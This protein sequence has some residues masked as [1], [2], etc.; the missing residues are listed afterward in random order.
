[1]ERRW[2]EDGKRMRMLKMTKLIVSP[3]PILESKSRITISLLPLKSL[4]LFFSSRALICIIKFGGK[5]IFE[6][7]MYKN[8]LNA[9]SNAESMSA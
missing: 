2:R 9:L 5:F 3:C 7:E 1:M 6:S 4:A 8:F